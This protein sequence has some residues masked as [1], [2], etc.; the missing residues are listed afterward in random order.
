MVRLKLLHPLAVAFLIAGS[1]APADPDGAD[2][3]HFATCTNA[4]VSRILGQDEARTCAAAFLRIKLSFVPKLSPE[5]YGRLT[6]GERA[7]ANRAGYEAYVRWHVGTSD[8]L[9]AGGAL[10]TD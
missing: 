7:A 10:G 5:T 2:L 6:P 4:A 8:R 1:A 3:A 9:F